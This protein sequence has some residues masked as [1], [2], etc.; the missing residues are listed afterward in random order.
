M[1][2][3]SAKLSSERLNDSLK[4]ITYLLEKHRLVIAMAHSQHEPHHD[5]VESLVQRQQLTKL[6]K[7]LDELHT[8][9]IAYILETL[10]KDDR[11]LIWQQVSIDR[12]GDVL[13]EVADSVRPALLEIMPDEDLKQSLINLSIDD[14]NLLADDLPEPILDDLRASLNR[15]ERRW[16]DIAMRYPEDQ[17]GRLMSSELVTIQESGTLQD[18]IE[19]V[20][21]LDELPIHLDKLF[22]I[23]QRRF[24]KGVLPLKSLLRS[25]PETPIADVMASD[26]VSFVPEDSADHAGLAFERYDLVSAPVIS[27]RGRLLGRLTVDILMDHIRDESNDDALN[28]A[29]LQG[30]EDLFASVTTSA[31]NRWVWL[32]IN[33]F[34]AFIA[35]RVISMFEQTISELIALAVL[36]P[37]VASI[38]GN[39]G[40]QTTALVIRGLA[41]SQI[42]PENRFHLL[43]KELSIALLNG[44]VWGSVVGLFALVVYHNPALSGVI[45]F[46]MLL[47]FLIAAL[48]GVAIPLFLEHIGRDPALGSSILLTATVDSMGF[49]IF[50]G[51]AAVTLV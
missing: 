21:E 17:V 40:N 44:L 32:G 49:F 35:S 1:H 18:A 39:S 5:L 26:A 51:L 38:G 34:T 41:L 12:R 43:R 27:E 7:H 29:G 4:M 16:M 48:A 42:K 24:L 20:R 3:V 28:M 22:V 11:V 15:R 8:A 19:L 33:L 50:L 6:K 37:I 30:E 36:M 23:D 45:S 46:A 9:D 13:L 47:N 31:R 25:R 14:L 2:E 10:P